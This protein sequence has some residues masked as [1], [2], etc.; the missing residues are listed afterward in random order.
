[1]L[2]L[3]HDLRRAAAAR[4][5]IAQLLLGGAGQQRP[6]MSQGRAAAAAGS[7]VQ[8]RQAA[9]LAVLSALRHVLAGALEP[10]LQDVGAIARLHDDP[11]AGAAAVHHAACKGPVPGGPVVNARG[12]AACGIAYAGS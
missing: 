4:H 6:S 8:A 1:M 10:D 7:H 2:S 9:K 11:S 12:H 5:V 3:P